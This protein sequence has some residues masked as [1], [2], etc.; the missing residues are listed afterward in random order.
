MKKML[1]LLLMTVLLTGC[2]VLDGGNYEK[3]RSGS[4]LDDDIL[5]SYHT[6]SVGEID[7]FRIDL[8]M[9]FFEAL[10][11]MSM[12]YSELSQEGIV[13]NIIVKSQLE[14]CGIT[15]IDSLPKYIRISNETFYFNVAENG[16]CSYDQ[17]FFHRL[18]YSDEV[19]DD[20][21]DVSPIEITYTTKFDHV[22]FYI[23]TFENVVFI[24]NIYYDSFGDEWEK[25]II[26]AVPM[27][28]RQ[29]G[30]IVEYN[31]DLMIE[32]ASIETYVLDNQSI[33]LL[34]LKEGFEDENINNI[35][36]ED[37]IDRLGRDHDIIK[38][39]RT[40]LTQRILDVIEDTL[41]RLGMF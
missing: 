2:G 32:L 34:E 11:T 12:D 15:E 27:S 30:N 16:N 28:V 31:E 22:D 10:E 33:N 26:T 1:L 40:K 9:S 36:S 25:D 8:V 39:V 21:E 37:T 35:W 19:I 13:K 14:T 5:I 24:E 23:N 20:L 18:G 7:V 6:N 41:S 4:V 29:S 38:T 17:Y 3:N